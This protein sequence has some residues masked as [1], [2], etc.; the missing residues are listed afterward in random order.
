METLV[1]VTWV[2]SKNSL[3]LHGLP[4][5]SCFGYGRGSEVKGN[6][7]NGTDG[8]VTLPY[9]TQINLKKK[10]FAYSSTLKLYQS[11][12]C[13]PQ[14]WPTGRSRPCD[15]LIVIQLS[16]CHFSDLR[17]ECQPECRAEE[18]PKLL[19][20]SNVSYDTAKR[21]PGRGHPSF[22]WAPL[23]LRSCEWILRDGGICACYWPH[24][25]SLLTTELWATYWSL[26]SVLLLISELF[27]PSLLLNGA[28]LGYLLLIFG[29]FYVVQMDL[30]SNIDT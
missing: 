30:L 8:K 26:K 27:K 18:S 1:L 16:T 21:R 17:S 5:T 22:C 24:H 23:H 20:G 25:F 19:L 4:L 15:G 29:L 2:G 13:I 6:F 11:V 3:Y 10:R 28:L 14:G 9:S 7:P 12:L